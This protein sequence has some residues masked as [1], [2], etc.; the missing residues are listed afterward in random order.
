MNKQ[1]SKGVGLVK[2]RWDKGKTIEL[3]DGKTR[4]LSAFACLDFL[5]WAA[6]VCHENGLADCY[7]YIRL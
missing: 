3:R 7:M 4:L 1:S 2:S 6:L 5:S